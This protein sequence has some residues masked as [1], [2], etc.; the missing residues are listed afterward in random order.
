M[1]ELWT[2]NV[3]FTRKL[4][5][6]IAMNVIVNYEIFCLQCCLLFLFCNKTLGN[7]KIVACPNKDMSTRTR[8]P[9]VFKY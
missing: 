9:M 5:Q 6:N 7:N 8:G 4:G 2:K 1:I 3:L